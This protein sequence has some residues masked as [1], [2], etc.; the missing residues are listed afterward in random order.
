VVECLASGVP[1]LTTR[2]GHVESEY[3]EFVFLLDDETAEGLAA[4]ICETMAMRED[5]R[6]SLALS[7]R[8]HV[9][10]HKTWDAQAAA[11]VAYLGSHVFSVAPHKQRVMALVDYYLPGFK[12]GGPAVSVSRLAMATREDVET[13][14]FT[15]DRDLATHNP[16]RAPNG[17]CGTGG[18]RRM[19]GTRARGRSG[20]SPCCAPSA[21]ASLTSCS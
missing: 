2:T 13:F 3:G 20:R 21:P 4:R 8:A 14:V 10:R 6:A 7:A 16:M 1:L 15:R 5:D 9:R 17:T 11:L 18:R 12:G 19:S